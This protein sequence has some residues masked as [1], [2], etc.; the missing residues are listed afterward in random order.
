MGQTESKDPGATPKP[1]R[2]F[3]TLDAT[4]RIHSTSHVQFSHLR[5]TSNIINSRVV[6]TGLHQSSVVCCGADVSHCTLVNT[7][8]CGGR[9]RYTVAHGSLLKGCNVQHNVFHDS[10]VSGL[11]SKHEV[12]QGQKE[13]GLETEMARHDPLESL[14]RRQEEEKEKLERE[15]EELS[16]HWEED[17]SIIPAN[18]GER[19]AAVVQ[20]ELNSDLKA[21][22][23][24]A[25]PAM[26]TAAEHAPPPYEL[27]VEDMVSGSKRGSV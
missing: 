25:N 8:V 27:V 12:L 5:D 14:R 11:H 21:G 13:D 17:E 24:R 19:S 7:R 20:D 15:G 4:S 10:A 16:A 22:E 2:S 18:G 6:H 9:L 3:N 23:V 1:K 26:E